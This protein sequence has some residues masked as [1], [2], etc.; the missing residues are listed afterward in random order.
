MIRLF[1]VFSMKSKI[2]MF[3]LCAL[4][5]MSTAQASLTSEELNLLPFQRYINDAMGEDPSL[6]KNAKTFQ[7]YTNESYQLRSLCRPSYADTILRTAGVLELCGEDSLARGE[8]TIAWDFDRVINAIN[9]AV[10]C[11]EMGFSLRDPNFPGVFS[12]ISAGGNQQFILTARCSRLFR[13]EDPVTDEE[14]IECGEKILKT[15]P[16]GSFTPPLKDQDQQVE[17]VYFHFKDGRCL[18]LYIFQSSV[19][20]CSAK[21]LA[22]KYFIDNNLFKTPPQKMALIDD[23][24]HNIESCEFLGDYQ[25][26]SGLPRVSL[27]LMHYP[28]FEF[29][30]L[31]CEAKMGPVPELTCAIARHA[32]YDIGVARE[33][34]GEVMVAAELIYRS[35]METDQEPEELLELLTHLEGS[36]E[37]SG[38][39]LKELI[40]TT[41]RE[42][43]LFDKAEHEKFL[44]RDALSEQILSPIPGGVLE[45]QSASGGRATDPFKMLGSAL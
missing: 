26:D 27:K 6:L 1:V 40:L 8:L 45:D 29:H 23:N 34:L 11:A 7:K 36:L 41:A 17:R 4:A 38:H 28:V 35:L 31:D 42:H 15:L 43:Y 37:G 18:P 14:L 10:G 20:F 2:K 19:V 22:L 25:P 16:Q 30:P 3:L 5:M 13:G 21:G 44:S 9:G 33:F 39:L 12:Q 24:L 32:L